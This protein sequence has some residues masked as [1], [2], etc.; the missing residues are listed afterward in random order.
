MY[1]CKIF[2]IVFTLLKGINSSSCNS[3]DVTSGYKN[4]IQIIVNNTNY[5]IYTL[6]W[7]NYPDVLKQKI[8]RLDEYNINYNGLQCG[9]NLVASVTNT[10]V[11]T[12]SIYVQLNYTNSLLIYDSIVLEELSKIL[13]DTYPS[14]EIG[15]IVVFGVFGLLFFILTVFFW[16]I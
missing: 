13:Y 11:W 1:F 12:G 7:L 8:I 6:Y 5:Q 9:W 3:Y 4:Y 15:L 14:F 16:C 2:T 10:G